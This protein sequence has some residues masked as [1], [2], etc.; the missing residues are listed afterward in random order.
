MNLAYREHERAARLLAKE[1]EEHG[2][3]VFLEPTPDQ[4]PFSLEGYSP[5]LFATKADDNLIIEI[6]SRESPK[7]MERYRKVIDIVQAHPGWKFLVKNFSST[8]PID[9]VTAPSS[10]D[11]KM[12][13]EYLDKAGKVASSDAPELAIP[14][15]WNSIIALLRNKATSAVPK[16]A[17]LPD[18][19]LVNQMYSLG[20][21]SAEQLETLRK[22]QELRD[23]AVHNIDF[24]AD[25]KE[26]NAMLAFARMLSTENQSQE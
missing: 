4:I 17:D 25:A 15:L 8:S 10:G 16:T 7:V 14:Y 11:V 24:T 13:Q 21:L 1:L 3:A 5:D 22:W 26:V 20:H 2:Y 19:S 6:G 18:L 23:R 12:I 9:D